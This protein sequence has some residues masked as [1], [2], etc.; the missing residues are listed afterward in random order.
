MLEG[1]KQRGAESEGENQRGPSRGVGAEGTKLEGKNLK[2]W[3]HYATLFEFF[4]LFHSFIQYNYT[5]FILHH[6]PR[7]VFLKR[8]RISGVRVG[9]VDA[10]GAKSEG[11]N[12]RGP[13]QRGG[14]DPETTCALLDIKPPMHL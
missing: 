9:G 6:S 5:P 1:Q 11:E 4:Y 8:G 14:M 3:W 7:P 10:E 2:V 12:Q 13:S